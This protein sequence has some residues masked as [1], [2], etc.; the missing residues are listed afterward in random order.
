MKHTPGPWAVSTRGVG[1]PMIWGNGHEVAQ[2]RYWSGS[3][4]VDEVDVN[5]RLIAAA[6]ELLEAA[7]IA[8]N[9]LSIRDA[10][11]DIVDA[12]YNL[13]IAITRATPW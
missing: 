13:R 12:L 9:L 5:A 2:V 8:D 6:P 7:K 10:E 3:E 1:A 11:P 4:N